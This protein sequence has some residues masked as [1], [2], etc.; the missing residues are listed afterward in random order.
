MYG[1][2]ARL[3]I[4]PGG[5]EALKATMAKYDDV[6]VPGS[7]ATYV[8][9]MDADPNEH[10]LVVLFEDRESY[11]RN[12]QDPAQ[13][14]RYRAMLEFLDGEPEWHDGEVVWASEGPTTSG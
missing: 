4:K 8:Y 14:E 9:R 11:R 5:T 2:I 12:A 10:M 1:T 6:D 13:D 7:V 3:R